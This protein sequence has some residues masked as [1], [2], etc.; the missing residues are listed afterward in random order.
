MRVRSIVE[1]RLLGVES[2]GIMIGGISCRLCGRAGGLGLLVPPRLALL[3]HV[4]CKKMSGAGVTSFRPDLLFFPMVGC[5]KMSGAA[6]R[7]HVA[8]LS[9]GVPP[10]LALLPHGWLQKNEWCCGA[11]S[12]RVLIQ[13]NP[14]PVDFVSFSRHRHTFSSLDD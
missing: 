12:R 7:C 10:R 4:G 13:R 9:R 6:V 11:V 2:H 3:P 5:K 14:D 1:G 8:S